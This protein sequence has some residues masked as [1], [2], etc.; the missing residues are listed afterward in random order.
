MDMEFTLADAPLLMDAASELRELTEIFT[1]HFQEP[2]TDLAKAIELLFD[3]NA[4]LRAE[5]GVLR[6]ALYPFTHSDLRKK[7]SGNEHG[8]ASVVF[9][10]DTAVLTLGDF[11]TAHKVF[12]EDSKYM[13][14]WACV[15]HH[16]V[17][18]VLG[19]RVGARIENAIAFVTRQSNGLWRW[20]TDAALGIEPSREL[21]MQEAQLAALAR[22]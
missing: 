20:D 18:W 21:A 16:P 8:R 4:R 7:L 17:R 14:E 10:R 3:E 13:L 22:P 5:R 19:Q 2:P 6:S 12:G 1:R 11:E 15:D 9:V